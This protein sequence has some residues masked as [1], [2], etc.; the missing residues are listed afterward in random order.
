MRAERHEGMALGEEVDVEDD[1]LGLARVEGRVRVG[2]G[3]G[4]AAVDGILEALDGAGGV[5]PVAEAVGDGLVGLLDVG[6][7]LG[8]ELGL[9]VGG[10]G[11]HR[12]GVGVFGFEIGDDFGR[13]LVAHP[14]VVVLEGDAVQRGGGGVAAGYGRLGGEAG[15]DSSERLGHS[16]VGLL[17]AFDADTD[18]L[19]GRCEDGLEK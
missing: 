2:V 8:V 5:E 10:G 19:Y 13:V 9:E 15:C 1:L 14:A 6:E 4:A 7:H 3:G 18:E 16:W 12:G 11:H 17:K